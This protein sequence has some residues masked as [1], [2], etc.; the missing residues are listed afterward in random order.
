M[1]ESLRHYPHRGVTADQNTETGREPWIERAAAWATEYLAS[2]GDAPVLAR[3]APGDLAGRLP[4]L[5]PEDGEPIESVFADLDELIVPALTHWNHPRFFGY[6]ANSSVPPAIA[7][8]VVAAATNQ[9]AMLWRTSPAATELETVTMRWVAALLGL[10][11][12]FGVIHDTAST[13]TM[14]ALHAARCRVDPDVRT[15]GAAGGPALAVYCSAEAHS[16]V[17]KAALVLGI[18]TD[19]V[20]HIPCDDEF[21]MDADALDDAMTQDRARGIVPAAVVATVG[22]TAVTAIDPVPRIVDIAREHGAW[23]HVDAAYGGAA[24]A[25]PRYR[26]VLDGVDAADS[27]V[28]NPHKW[29]LVPVDCSVLLLADPEATRSAFSLVPDYLR[30]D[31]EAVNYMDYGVSLGRRFRALKLW[32]TMR[33]MGTK[34]IAAAIESHIELARDL[35]ARIDASDAFERVAPAPLSVVNFTCVAPDGADP[36]DLNRRIVDAVNRSG[37]AFLTTAAVRGLTAIHAAV[38]NAATTARDIAVLWEALA[39]ARAS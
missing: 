18:G 26:W 15:R 12:T 29:L 28:V 2:V 13:S 10:P 17:D 27:V 3:T 37:I 8:E 20:R 30:T 14:C 1:H 33:S 6:F 23:V 24:A 31:E 36:S 7:A 39:R 21:R 38:G 25:S 4:P 32:M 11:Q 35:A 16:S 34:G 5:A 19:S 22:T 9:N